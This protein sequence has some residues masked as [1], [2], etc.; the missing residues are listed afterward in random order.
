MKAGTQNSWAY[1]LA[2]DLAGGVCY[3]V[4]M[5]VFAMH[6][7]FAPGGVSGLALLLNRLLGL[8][9]GLGTLLLNLPLFALSYRF[10]GRRFLART[11]RSM[12][13]CVLLLDVVFPQFP[14][15]TGEPFLA[16]LYSG[17]FLGAGLALF[18]MHGSSSGGMDL[19]TMTIKKLRPHLS[20]GAVMMAIDLVVILLG[21]PVFG[22]VDAVLYGLTAVVVTAFVLDKIMYGAGACM[23]VIIITDAGQAVAR[24]IAARCGRGSTQIR[25]LGS[26]TGT[27]RYVLLCACGKAQA[28]KV[29]TAA[30]E[31]DRGA[32]VMVTEASGGAGEGFSA[33]GGPREYKGPSGVRPEVPLRTDQ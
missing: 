31:I 32:F 29:R 20:V 3:A 10:V 2:A 23:L 7:D 6:A 13:I 17:A 27:E 26:Y 18:Y 9:V 22:N 5:Y 28:Y 16:A 11:L 21:W 8:P 14:A 12:M 30:H 24:R 15:Y 1:D 25:A 33:P 4:G 19:L